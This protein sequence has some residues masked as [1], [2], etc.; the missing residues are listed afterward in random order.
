MLYQSTRPG[1]LG[2]QEEGA[3]IDICY[4]LSMALVHHA[5]HLGDI[6]KRKGRRN[7]FDFAEIHE[8]RGC[9]DISPSCLSCPLP[10][11][12]HDYCFEERQEV[13]R[14]FLEWKARQG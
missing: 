14:Q 7:S 11:C 2:G 3:K 5:Q 12:L 1:S 13:R 8:D 9:K 6:A 4:A 10:Q